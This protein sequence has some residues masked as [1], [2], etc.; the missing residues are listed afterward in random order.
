MCG[1]IYVN[2]DKISKS[3]VEKALNK[4]EY[5]GPDFK[6]TKAYNNNFFLSHCRLSILDV[7]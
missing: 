1:F 5:R 2:S 7:S 4:I 3:S 6:E